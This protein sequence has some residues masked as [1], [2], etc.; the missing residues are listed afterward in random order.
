[1]ISVL[2]FVCLY[3]CV[4][5]YALVLYVR[6]C[7]LWVFPGQ[8]CMPGGVSFQCLEVRCRHCSDCATVVIQL[9]E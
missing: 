7:V 8:K 5:V 2:I 9:K 6:V 4:C 1:M 3:V